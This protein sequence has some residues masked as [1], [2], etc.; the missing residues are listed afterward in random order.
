VS[1][2]K[3]VQEAKGHGLKAWPYASD[4]NGGAGQDGIIY[5]PT[6]GAAEVPA[7]GND[8][9]V[10]YRLV[11]IHAPGGLWA[12]AL[13]DASQPAGQAATFSSFGTFKGD[14][15]GGCGSGLKSCG[16]NSA[17]APWGWD[18]GND[19]SSSYRGEF[20]LDPARLF[21]AYF[22]GLGN[23]S[24]QYVRNPYLAGLQAAGYGSANPPAGFASQLDLNAM[25]GK[26][27]GS[28]S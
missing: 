18:D 16:T 5:Y 26:L 15:S 28:C 1:R 25:Y 19:G 21:S 22:G 8:R 3:T 27:V 9:S 10:A 17:N 7:S 12:A 11:D 24:Q 2:A 14:T 4:F 23:F 20:A 6:Q 13:A